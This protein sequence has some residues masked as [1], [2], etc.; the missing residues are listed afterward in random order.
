MH[1]NG[2]VRLRESSYHSA[3][4][5][6]IIFGRLMLRMVLLQLNLFFSQLMIV[7]QLSIV[8]LQLTIVLK[9]VL[10]FTPLEKR[11]RVYL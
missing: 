10:D 7:F 8:E 4:L 3:V 5:C 1:D 6:A 11:V 9:S 2:I